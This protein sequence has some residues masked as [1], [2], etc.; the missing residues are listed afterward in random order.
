[1]SGDLEKC[2]Q[3]PRSDRTDC[4][5]MTEKWLSVARDMSVSLDAGV[6]TVQTECGPREAVF[7]AESHRVAAAEVGEAEAERRLQRYLQA[8]Q[9]PDVEVVSVKI[10]T[11]YSQISPIARE[12]AVRVLCDRMELLYRAAAKAAFRAAADAG[13]Q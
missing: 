13:Q 5:A 12:H 8:L 3:L 11:L 2:T 7:P 6:E 4:I 9:N 1:M 10:S